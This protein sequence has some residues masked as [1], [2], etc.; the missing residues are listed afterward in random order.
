[1][2]FMLSKKKIKHLDASVLNYSKTLVMKKNHQIHFKF[3]A[4]LQFNSST[5]PSLYSRETPC[6]YH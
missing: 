2:H 5:C 6:Q 3:I 4:F 1:M